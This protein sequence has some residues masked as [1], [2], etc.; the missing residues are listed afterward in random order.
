MLGTFL[1]LATLQ[2]QD[3]DLSEL[4]ASLPRWQSHATTAPAERRAHL[5]GAT[6]AVTNKVLLDAPTLAAAE[7][8]KLICIAATGTN[9]VDLAAAAEQGIQVCNVRDYAVASVGQHTLAL[10]LGLATQW[11]RYQAAVQRGDWSRSE[12]FCLM[13]YPAVELAG[14]T[15]G[16]VGYGRLGQEVA[17]LGAA[18]G[19]QVQ[20]AASLRANAATEAGRLPLEH[21]LAQSDVLSLHCP[22]TPETAGLINA[23]RLA[24]MK[25]GALLVNTAR[26][27]L[28]DEAALAAALRSGQLGGAAL[29]T[30]SVEPPPADHPLLGM[31][32][33]NL[34]LTPHSAWL[35]REA[36]QRL[37]GIV[38]DNIHSWRQG[39]LHNRVV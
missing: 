39:A 27:G 19:M 18:L 12:L 1:D 8:L 4:W 36:R 3:L 7:Q 11:A 22:L 20:V 37:I 6:V 30:L 13:D 23:E 16:I 15:L 25:R 2:P 35:A 9:N 38:A 28:I 32:D 26:G 31:R 5:H 34:I 17:R 14:R 24:L 29:D 21:V 33:C 10:M